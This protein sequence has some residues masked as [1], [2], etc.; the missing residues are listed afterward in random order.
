MVTAS[1]DGKTEA[2]CFEQRRS[3]SLATVAAGSDPGDADRIQ[4]LEHVEQCSRAEVERMIVGERHAVD[5]E[6]AEDLGRGRRCPE[7]KRLIWIGPGCA[8][9]GDTALQVEN[10]EVGRLRDR[11]HLVC[12]DR[13]RAGNDESLSHRA[14]Q[15]RVTGESKR[16]R[17][18][19]R[20]HRV[21]RRRRRTK[22][23]PT[24]SG[25]RAARI[26]ASS[27]GDTAKPP[28][29]A[30]TVARQLIGRSGVEAELDSALV[31]IVRPRASASA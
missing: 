15:H 16:S 6:P 5:A 19:E 23:A 21:E 12:D 11:N 8:P 25:A 22:S 26:T 13:L 18:A 7:E 10:E 9:R 24:T 29:S 3:L 17:R 14:P 4:V 28:D 31:L 2:V 1:E 30:A 20:A 27:G